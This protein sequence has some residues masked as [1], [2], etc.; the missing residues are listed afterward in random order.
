MSELYFIITLIK[1]FLL[2]III[3]ITTNAWSDTTV[4]ILGWSQDGLVA[5]S[6]NNTDKQEPIKVI[7]DLVDDK[8]IYRDMSNEK[9]ISKWNRELRDHK[10]WLNMDEQPLQSIKNWNIITD[11]ETF[12]KNFGVGSWISEY[13]LHLNKNGKTKDVTHQLGLRIDNVVILGTAKNPFENRIV[14]FVLEK[15]SSWNNQGQ[16]KQTIKAFGSHL[17]LGFN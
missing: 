9:N 2:P 3:L 6:L 17:N 4:N 8:V 11:I 16:E 10:I 15:K 12:E 13:I 7:F 5:Y 14:I 1:Y